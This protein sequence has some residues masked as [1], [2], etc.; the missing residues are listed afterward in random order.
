[1]AER[2]N[3]VWHKMLYRPSCTNGNSGRQRVS[4]MRYSS[5]WHCISFSQSLSSKSVIMRRLL[6]RVIMDLRR[7]FICCA[8]C[9]SSSCRCSSCCSRSLRNS[10]RRRMSY[11]T[12]ESTVVTATTATDCT[13]WKVCTAHISNG[14]VVKTGY[15]E[16][17]CVNISKTVGFTSNDYY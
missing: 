12:G 2:L 9:C 13:D 14:G 6:R 3:P 11:L 15:F 5:Y 4:V 7:D 16:A 8:F 1:M 17:K 10:S